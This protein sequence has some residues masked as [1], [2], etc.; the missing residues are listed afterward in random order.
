MS[1]HLPTW[2]CTDIPRSVSE[3]WASAAEP[4]DPSPEQGFLSPYNLQFLTWMLPFTH[5]W[6]GNFCADHHRN[7]QIHHLVRPF[8]C[9]STELASENANRGRE[10]S[11]VKAVPF[12]F[13]LAKLIFILSCPYSFSTPTQAFSLIIFLWG[14]PEQLCCPC[15]LSG[16]GLLSQTS[17]WEWFGLSHI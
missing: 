16:M 8:P 15:C 7:L 3:L 1:S 17:T 10:R 11:L 12:F 9:C 5:G 2:S 13:I 4:R 14:F 6:A